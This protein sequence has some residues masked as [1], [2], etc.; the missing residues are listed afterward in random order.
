MSLANVHLSAEE[1]RLVLDPAVILT[2]N[3]VME[4]VVALMAGFE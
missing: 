4:K 3:S 2:K 1:M